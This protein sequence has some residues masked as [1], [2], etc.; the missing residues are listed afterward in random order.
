MASA[1]TLNILAC[2][3]VRMLD[4]GHNRDDPP[5]KTQ[6][7][8]ESIAETIERRIK[9]EGDTHDSIGALIED[10]ITMVTAW[11]PGENDTCSP[12]GENDTI[13]CREGRAEGESL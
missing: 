11:M 12:T 5:D 13:L 2:L 3:V 4:C 10:G 9:Q 1:P 7:L 8:L 6:Q